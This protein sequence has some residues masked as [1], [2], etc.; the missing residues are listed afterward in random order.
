MV[1]AEEKNQLWEE[2]GGSDRKPVLN[3]TELT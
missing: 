3:R 2:K 1:Q